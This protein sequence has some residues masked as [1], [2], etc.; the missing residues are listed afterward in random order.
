MSNI[1]STSGTGRV[2]LKYTSNPVVTSLVDTIVICQSTPSAAHLQLNQMLGLETGG[3][4]SY[5]ALLS[6]YITA[7]MPPSQFAGAYIFDAAAAW[8]ATSSS[9]SAYKITYNGD[10]DA[11]AFTFKYT[12]GSQTCFGNSERRLVLVVTSRIQ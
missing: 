11:A 3:A 6:P 8:A 12:T 9:L 7:K 5:E 10:T 2:Y 4:W 1:C